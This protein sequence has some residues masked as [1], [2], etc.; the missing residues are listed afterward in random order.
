VS[1]NAS[2]GQTFSRS[3]HSISPLDMRE[4]K[5]CP[6]C[7]RANQT[8]SGTFHS[9]VKELVLP[10]LQEGVRTNKKCM[11]RQDKS[12]L[13]PPRNFGMQTWGSAEVCL[14]APE[15]SER[16]VRRGR[17]VPGHDKRCYCYTNT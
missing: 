11:T 6:K 13:L 3:V 12:Q 9:I 2:Q 8:G 14:V 7:G 17:K 4:N 1:L 15:N 5:P 10:G 16:Q